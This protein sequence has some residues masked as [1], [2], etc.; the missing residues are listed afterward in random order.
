MA[1]VSTLPWSLTEFNSPKTSATI[2]RTNCD[3]RNYPRPGCR[4]PR[5]R[6]KD[7]GFD[8]VVYSRATLSLWTRSLRFCG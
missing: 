8:L 5:L 7:K 3:W 2:G 4:T 6:L 1:P